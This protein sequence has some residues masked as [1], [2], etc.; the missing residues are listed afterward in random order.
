MLTMVASSAV[1]S[2]ASAMNA[3]PIHRRSAACARICSA[4]CTADRI[5]APSR[6]EQ[7]DPQPD[8]NSQ[9]DDQDR[10]DSRRLDRH[11]EED[12]DRDGQADVE[13]K[14]KHQNAKPG[15]G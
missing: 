6:R 2:W 14:E 10:G 8:G 15:S 5:S 7:A 12:A 13:R 9:D 4:R 3:S 1:I 11:E